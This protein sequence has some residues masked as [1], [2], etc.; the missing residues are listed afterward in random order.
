M[1]LI[2]SLI[3]LYNDMVFLSSNISRCIFMIFLSFL[4]AGPVWALMGSNLWIL[5][6]VSLISG[7]KILKSKFSCSISLRIQRIHRGEAALRWWDSQCVLRREWFPNRDRFLYIYMKEVIEV[8][9]WG[10]GYTN[11]QPVNFIDVDE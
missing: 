3:V 1:S 6:T 9:S 7:F 11:L 2:I 5:L 4:L 10:G 8:L